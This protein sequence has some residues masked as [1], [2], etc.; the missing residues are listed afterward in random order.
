MKL[1]SSGKHLYHNN[2]PAP[3]YPPQNRSHFHYYIISLC[4]SDGSIK[5]SSA[6]VWKVVSTMKKID[7]WE[8]EGKKVR[9]MTSVPPLCHVCWKIDFKEGNDVRAL[10]YPSF[11]GS[12]GSAASPIQSFVHGV[13]SYLAA[14]IYSVLTHLWPNNF[15]HIFSF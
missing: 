5:I 2:T 7:S 8:D 15:L 3:F 13:Y 6:Q 11:I 12:A 1:N 14:A 10:L 9:S 4:I